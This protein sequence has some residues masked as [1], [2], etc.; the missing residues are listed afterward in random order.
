[1]NKKIIGTLLLPLASLVALPVLAGHI[2]LENQTG[3]SLRMECGDHEHGKKTGNIEPGHSA[4]IP[5][6]KKHVRCRAVNRHGET[7]ESR[8]FNNEHGD[9]HT[10]WRVKGHRSS[11]G[12][13]GNSGGGHR[14]SGGH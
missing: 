12:G 7:V 11:G 3:Q 13:H 8:T 2:T 14:S 9:E 1:M 5:N 6:H 10:T 4:G